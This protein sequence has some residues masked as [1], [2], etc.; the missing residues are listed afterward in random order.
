MILEP[1]SIKERSQDNPNHEPQTLRKGAG[2]TLQHDSLGVQRPR[3]PGR[4]HPMPQRVRRARRCSRGRAS[5][6][7]GLIRAQRDLSHESRDHGS[8][9]SLCC[10][11]HPRP[12]LQTGRGREQNSAEGA[13]Q[14]RPARGSLPE[15]GLAGRV[16][17]ALLEMVLPTALLR[18]GSRQHVPAQQQGRAG[19]AGLSTPPPPRA[20]TSIRPSTE[21]SGDRARRGSRD[22]RGARGVAEGAA[23]LDGAACSVTSLCCAGTDITRAAAHTHTL[24]PRS[25]R[26]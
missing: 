14:G 22:F 10:I 1:L 25:S 8:T 5:R 2:E 24:A 21:P 13:P 17:S 4:T 11:P 15:R 9:M 12:K 18:V 26:G 7:A 19:G 23:S 16:A 3:R 6:P 20:A